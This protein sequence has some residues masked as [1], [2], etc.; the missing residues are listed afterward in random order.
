M[1]SPH[2]RDAQSLERPVVVPLRHL[3]MASS[4][5]VVMPAL[6]AAASRAARSGARS[7]EIAHF[8]GHIENFEH[9]NAS[10]IAKAAAALAPLRAIDGFAGRTPARPGADRRPNRR[11]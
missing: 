3:A 5:M 1:A 6:V 8:A 2:R 9:A 10:P 4:I 11:N 7:D